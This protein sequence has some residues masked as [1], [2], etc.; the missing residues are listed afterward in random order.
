[1]SK[2]AKNTKSSQKVVNMA[3]ELKAIYSNGFYPQNYLDQSLSSDVKSAGFTGDSLKSL[4]KTLEPQIQESLEELANL[5]ADES[6]ILNIARQVYKTLGWYDRAATQGEHNFAFT[7]SSQKYELPVERIV[8]LRNGEEV[9][10]LVAVPTIEPSKF[11]LLQNTECE[12]F[13]KAKESVRKSWEDVIDA[14]FDSDQADCSY[15]IVNQ[16]IYLHLF[17]RG[18]W[19]EDKASL[20]VFINEL[21]DFNSDDLY[22]LAESLFSPKAFSIDSAES[23]HETLAQNAHKKAAQ[24]TKALRDTLREAI[25]VLANEVLAAHKKAPLMAWESRN[26]SATDDS[27]KCSRELFEQS[28]RY[29]YRTL[30]M[31]FTESQPQ[32]KESLPVQSPIYQ[33]GYSFERLR[34]LEGIPLTGKGDRNFIQQSLKRISKIYYSGFNNHIQTVFDKHTDS[35]Q[36]KTDALGFAFPSLG[37]SLF[38]LETTP[39]IEEAHISDNTMQKVIKLLSLAKTGTGSN[40]R[41]YR[42][43]YAG[44]GL[45]QLGAA[46]EGLLSLRP[47]ILDEKVVLLAKESKEDA[48]RFI[49]Y[50]EKSKFDESLLATDDETGNIVVKEKGEFVL[51]PRGLDRKLSASFYTP[52]VLTRFV[53]KEAVEALL[54]KDLSLKKLEN[55]KIL[56]PAM[57][58]GAFTNAVVDELAPRLAKHYKL[59]DEKNKLET[60]DFEF[61]KAKAKSH[62]MK[63]CVYGVDLNPTAVELAKVSLWLN[64]LHSDGNLPFLDFKLRT[65][66]SLVGAWIERHKDEDLDV[67][68]FLIP[69][70]AVLDPHLDGLLL[71]EKKKPILTNDVLR[72]KLKSIKNDFT[73]IKK[74]MKS[75][76]RIKNLSKIVTRLFENHLKS[77][78]DYQERLSQIRNPEE[79]HLAFVEYAE[80]NTA[81]NQLRSLMDYWCSL[82]F[83]PHSELESFPNVESFLESM[84]W[85]AANK[86]GYGDS[87]TSKI[88]TS[89]LESILVARDVALREKF[90]HWDLEF[91][92]V[93][94]NGGGFDLCIGNPPWAHV[95]WEESDFF[96]E[97]SPGI[98]ATEGDANTRNTA[99]EKILNSNFAG[100]ASYKNDHSRVMGLANFLAESSTYPFRDSSKTNT[101]KFFYQRFYQLTLNGGIHAMIAQ[102]GILTDEGCLEMRPQFL[103]ESRRLFRFINEKKL[104][105]DIGNLRPFIVWCNQRGKSSSQIELIDNLY[106]PETVDKCRQ[107]SPL[108]DYRGMKDEVG[109]FETRGHPKRII[110]LTN[111]VLSD[112]VKF[113]PGSSVHNLSIPTIHG[114]VELEV[115]R[116]FARHSEKLQLGSGIYSSTSFN[117]SEAPKKGYIKRNAGTSIDLAHS[118]LTGPNIFVSNPETS[119]SKEKRTC[120]R[121]IFF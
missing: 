121:F 5:R 117:E 83:W 25:E 70:F 104:F 116:A 50:S 2:A 10:M 11:D 16:G 45:N 33:R 93:L 76:E 111:E 78:I 118:V 90:F 7:I 48:F 115:L 35:N 52:E 26:L 74:D 97:L 103:C 36:I 54:E 71:G 64:C 19:Q 69:N 15:M 46:Y 53:A 66:N 85:L 87:Q 94:A 14:L 18:K 88:K 91:S 42:I 23:L 62:L 3:T 61:Y 73:N 80:V 47:E 114:Q 113:S 59:G 75:V 99:Y 109:N 65:G 119:S 41:T 84:E 28:L 34:D 86:Q 55:L 106:L 31:L 72:E 57:G 40:K 105:E 43:H 98:S 17:E 110:K 12:L 101:Y 79:K 44:L 107:E 68:Q 82:W 24:V 8:K 13:V 120:F 1:M 100:L 112:L 63:N 92:E 95:K 20:S 9:W 56:E 21:F 81:Y 67:P 38:N 27:K 29:V 89:K 51:T 96:E 6:Q 37:T 108:T 39:L 49:P 77:R 60:K 4:K 22:R 58:S 102:D 32:S 30:F